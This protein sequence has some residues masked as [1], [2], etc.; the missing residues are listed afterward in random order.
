MDKTIDMKRTHRYDQEH[1][2]RNDFQPP[3]GG[4]TSSVTQNHPVS[5]T[6]ICMRKED[7][8]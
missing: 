6:R 7:T 1:V 4:Q 2:L 5:F 8:F 3:Y